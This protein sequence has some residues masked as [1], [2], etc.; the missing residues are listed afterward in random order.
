MTIGDEAYQSTN[1]SARR[2][3][4]GCVGDEHFGRSFAFYRKWKANPQTNKKGKQ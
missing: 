3:A 2:S 1:V 4:V